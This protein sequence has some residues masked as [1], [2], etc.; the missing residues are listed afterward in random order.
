MDH[1]LRP[2]LDRLPEASGVYLMKDAKG[3]VIYV[4]KAA[5]LRQRV[6]SYF[7]APE[8]LD[9]KTATLAQ[10]IQDFDFVVTATEPEALLLE[11]Q[12]IKEYRPH[13]NIR[14]KDDKRFPWLKLSSSE[15]FPRLSV[16]RRRAEDG[17]DYFG[18]YTDAKAMRRTLKTI[19]QIFQ[20]RTCDLALPKESVPRPCLDYYIQRCGAPC[21]GFVNQEEYGALVEQVRLFLAGRSRGLI[22]ILEQ[23]MRERSENRQFEE[24]GKLRDQIEAVHKVVARQEVV[25]DAGRD[26][27]VYGLEREGRQA[28]GVLLRVRDGKLLH[29]ESYQLSARLDD[30]LGEFFR[31]FVSERLS[32]E[33][34]PAPE[35]L[36]LH[37]L[38]GREDWEGLLGERLERRVHLKVPQRGQGRRLVEM[39]RTNARWKL[40]EYLARNESRRS[41]V[42]DEEPAVLDLK[43]RLKLAVAPHSIE[44][45]DMSHFQGSHRV[46]SLVY[47]QGGEPYKSRY[48]RFKIQ[49]V[50]GI[51]DFGMMQE[52]L[53]RYYSRLRDE[54]K[55][56][57]DLVVVDGGAGQLSV[58]LRT[59]Q[60]YGFVET[61][62]IGL[63]KREEEIYLPGQAEPVQLPRSSAGLKLLQRTRDEAHRFAVSYHRNLRGKDVKRS[64]LDEVPGIG[65]VKKRALLSRFSSAEAVGKASAQELLGVKGIGQG[66]VERIEAFFAKRGGRS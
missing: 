65:A 28:C 16:V 47:F 36:L 23:R 25:L 6:R 44:C 12:L 62:V 13:Y 27:D 32:S 57:A 5:R 61:A 37:E 52:V 66:D 41:R 64:V 14:L 59:L 2:K 45:F 33:A 8:S 20:V 55:L 60:R 1:P 3:K 34:H 63:A 53:E 24:A 11:D 21:V 40:K 51:D 22:E 19:T 50:E 31:R 10:R 38:D 9:P 46:G 26:V 49:Q 35:I 15:P 54:D 56:P 43:D 4:G 7:A 18:P 29:T 39:A 48:R 30:E 42:S 58:A 17:D